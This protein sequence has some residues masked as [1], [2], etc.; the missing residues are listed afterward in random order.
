MGVVVMPNTAVT[1]SPGFI[2]IAVGDVN[3]SAAFYENYLGE[4]PAA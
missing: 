4:S 1:P 2:S 3:R